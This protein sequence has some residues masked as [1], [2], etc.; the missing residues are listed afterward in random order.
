MK[1]WQRVV[2]V[3]VAAGAVVAA[4]GEVAYA[5]PPVPVKTR[6][7]HPVT[8]PDTMA[9]GLVHL[10]N[11]GTQ[12]MMLF[13]KVHAG[14]ALLVRDVN[15]QFTLAGHARLY[16]QFHAVATILEHADA[17]VRLRPGT[18]YLF[19]ADVDRMHKDDVHV[20]TVQGATDNARAPQVRPV[21]VQLHTNALIA[22]RHVHAGRFFHF[23]NRTHHA[24]ELIYFPVSPSAT[25]AQIKAF[26]DAPSLPKLFAIVD[27][28]RFDVSVLVVT[29]AGEDL[30]VR[31]PRRAGRYAAIT[32]AYDRPTTAIRRHAAAVVTVS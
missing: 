9:P 31:Y 21:T 26:L 24:Q 5:R 3:V 12:P 11:V 28:H 15:D 6:T 27:V 18:Y 25:A 10:R 8:A 17:Y 4:S 29:G 30:Y 23:R 19:A 20:I 7:V 32:L 1:R 16:R 13:R 14:V 22:P 2:A